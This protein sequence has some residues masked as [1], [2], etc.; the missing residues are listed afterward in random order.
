MGGG[1]PVKPVAPAPLQAETKKETAKVPASAPGTKAGLPQAT[2]QLQRPAA[3]SKSLSTS[4]VI[5]VPPGDSSSEL[6]PVLG[7][8]ALVVA[9][10]S[11][12][13]QLWMMLA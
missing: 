4:G 10:L 12:G 9:L 8:A 6:S 11:L 1:S 2:V 3:T 13:V 7:I 5:V